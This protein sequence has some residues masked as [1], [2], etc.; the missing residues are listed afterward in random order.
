M[1]QTEGAHLIEALSDLKNT[2]FYPRKALE[3]P[4]FLQLK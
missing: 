4:T 3:P 2:E 1:T